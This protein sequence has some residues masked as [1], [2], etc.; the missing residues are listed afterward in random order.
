MQIAFQGFTSFVV[1]KKKEIMSEFVR[2]V[3]HEEDTWRTYCA[4][5]SSNSSSLPIDMMVLFN[6][7]FLSLNRMVRHLSYLHLSSNIIFPI[8]ETGYE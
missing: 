8:R 5:F 7:A 4:T 1:L 3:K 2:Y 6:T